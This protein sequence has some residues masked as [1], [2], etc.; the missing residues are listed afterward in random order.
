MAE[1]PF[2]T[3]ADLESHTK[4][5]ILQSDPR[6][7]GALAAVSHSIR[8]ECGWH[9]W[10]VK[11]AH[12]MTLDGPGGTKIYLPTQRLQEI[13][14]VAEDGVS[15]DLDTLDWSELGI[16]EKYGCGRWTRRYRKIVAVIKHGY[17]EVP[18]LKQVTLDLAAR[19]LASPMGATREQAGSLSVNWSMVQP[20]TAG[21][22]V[23]LNAEKAVVARY[24]L[25]AL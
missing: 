14:S 13:V 16:V 10:P 25:E 2:A 20:G 12:E 19:A 7:L 23:P 24:R 17:D 15:L 1:Q 11:E 6:A 22:M 9:I 8:M 3:P 21:G 18:D 4:G 5:Q